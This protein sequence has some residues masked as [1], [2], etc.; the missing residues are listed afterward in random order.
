MYFDET[1]WVAIAF[2]IFIGLVWRKAS[3]AITGILDSRSLLIEN[4]LNEAK[5][6]KEEALEELRKSL[7]SQ[8][9]I[10]NEA[11]QI[12]KDAQDA[13]K[14]IRE[15]T[16]VICSEIIKRREEQAKQ[17]IMALETEAVNNIKKI[18]G[19]IIIESSKVFIESNLDKKENNNIISKSS[20]QIKS[21]FLN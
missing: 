1:A 19:S 2:V 16:N 18:T 12:I 10:S 13:A 11:E 4:E 8:K 15:D 20:N 6:L 5:S 7:Q 9:N 3:K 21:S 17:K 14:K